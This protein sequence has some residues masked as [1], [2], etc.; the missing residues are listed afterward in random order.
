[1][2]N[3]IIRFAIAWFSLQI[4]PA[5]DFRKSYTIPADTQIIVEN[6]LGNI[7]LTSHKGK[8]VELIAYKKGSSN[9]PIEIKEDR[10]GDRFRIFSFN[11]QF[12][13]RRGYPPS[14]GSFPLRG[15]PPSMGFPPPVAPAPPDPAIVSKSSVDFEIR[16]PQSIEYKQV[17]LSSFFGSG[18]I[19][20]SEV[21]G[22]FSI[23]TGTGSV[24]VSEVK[25]HFSIQTRTGSM[26][27]KNVIGQVSASST[28]GTISINLAH[29]NDP[30]DM[31]FSSTSGN[32]IVIAPA[33]LSAIVDMWSQSSGLLQTNFDLKIEEDRYGRGKSVHGGQLGKGKDKLR[34][35]SNFG[36][37]SLMHK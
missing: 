29:A 18:K 34:L 31:N 19:V 32:V 21:K 28:S 22:S 30:R 5:D 6:Y 35:Y 16:M 1:M 36:Q 27:I 15:G 11:P 20:V 9:D 33:N 13:P 23:L 12:T 8:T 4:A 17:F 7:K 2:R 10:S 3:G 26:E 24:D 25:G 14:R 37:V